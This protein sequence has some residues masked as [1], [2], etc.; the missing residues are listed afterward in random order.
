MI[1]RAGY[2]LHAAYMYQDIRALHRAL[3]SVLN[4]DRKVIARVW[5]ESSCAV[6]HFKSLVWSG[7]AWFL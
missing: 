7:K 2:R 1:A 3:K 6:Q 5:L 4:R